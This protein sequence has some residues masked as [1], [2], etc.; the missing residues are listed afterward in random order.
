MERQAREDI[1]SNTKLLSDIQEIV[2]RAQHTSV[3]DEE[4]TKVATNLL[5]CLT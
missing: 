4:A 1:F 5:I 2:E 3:A